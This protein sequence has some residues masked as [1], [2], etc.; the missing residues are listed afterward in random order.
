MV[1]SD[2]PFTPSEYILLNADKYAPDTQGKP[3]HNLLCSDGVVD[4]KALAS[5]LIVASI[6]VNE[7]E[8][9][10]EIHSGQSKRLFRA[11]TVSH[12][13]LRPQGQPPNWSAY[14][15][16]NTV[17]FIIG[18]LVSMNDVNTVRNVTYEVI[19]EDRK[20]PW[21]KIIEV[22]EWGLASCNW[23]IPVEGEAAA[24]FS[25]PFICPAKVRDLVLA[26]PEEPVKNLL[27]SCKH[28]RPE[29][30]KALFT[31]IDLAFRDRRK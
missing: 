3:G 18:Q 4:A 17:L 15:L 24:A 9:A 26:Q 1:F 27:S 31:E 16:E 13:Y 22:V 6:L 23:L 12:V 11:D 20:E 5:M 14:T 29:V 7:S 10:L 2:F 21:Q 30:W 25:T 8:S 19:R 28:D